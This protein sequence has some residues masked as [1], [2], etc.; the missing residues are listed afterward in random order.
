V[1]RYITILVLFLSLSA[2]AHEPTDTLHRH[3]DEVQ[4]TASV[5][6]DRREV[7]NVATTTLNMRQMDMQGIASVKDI[8]LVAPN[9]YQPD[10]GSSMTSSIYVRGFGSRIDQPVLGITI[11][12]RVTDVFCDG[13][14]VK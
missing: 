11:D 13:E 7:T 14:R 9:F 6:S 3:I 2:A 1:K 10:Y 4:I 12:D 5:K 8:S